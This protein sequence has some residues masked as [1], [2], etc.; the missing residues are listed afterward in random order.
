[1]EQLGRY[2]AQAD[3]LVSPRIRG[4]NT[5]MKIYSYL[6]SGKA[7]IA[8]RLPTHTQVLDDEISLL[9]DPEPGAVGAG[10]VRLLRDRALASSLA[11]AA[12]RR[13]IREFTREAYRRKLGEFYRGV[14][15]EVLAAAAR[16]GKQ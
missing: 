5:P 10:L 9:V 13:A 3:L 15:E 7:L 14:E 2:L 6:D 4:L 16:K 8:T 12:K 11:E 1:M